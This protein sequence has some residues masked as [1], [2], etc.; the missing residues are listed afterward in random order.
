MPTEVYRY[1]HGR[2]EATNDN[3]PEDMPAPYN[4]WELIERVALTLC[5]RLPVA[6]VSR[7][8]G[9]GGGRR[10]EM[11]KARPMNDT[12]AWGIILWKT[13][14]VVLKRV[15]GGVSRL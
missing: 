9:K 8:L 1:E 14:T 13:T 11:R 6:Y 7:P 5:C 15:L 12:L 2:W 4:K 10:K 3:R